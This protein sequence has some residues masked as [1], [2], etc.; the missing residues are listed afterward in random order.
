MDT[1]VQV[2]L[3]RLLPT[4]LWAGAVSFAIYLFRHPIAGLIPNIRRFKVGPSGLE[5]ELI[6]EE[7]KQAAAKSPE[8]VSPGDRASVQRRA[9]LVA[10]A[11]KGAQVLWVDDN[12]VGNTAERRVLKSLGI[13]IDIAE[14]TD[15]GI[16]MHRRKFYDAIISDMKRQTDG[17]A[18]SQPKQQVPDGVRFLQELRNLGPHPRTILYF[19]DIDWT[20]GLPRGA[21]AMTNRPDHLMHYVMDILERERA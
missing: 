2:E 4:L 1:Q 3:I 13:T 11:L 6:N 14:T 5:L 15:E 21:F 8:D 10:P 18:T 19:F 16:A 7:L 20:L 12:P 9:A 17:A